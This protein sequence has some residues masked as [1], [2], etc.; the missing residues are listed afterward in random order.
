MPPGLLGML[1][2]VTPCEEARANAGT[3]GP[4]S[5]IGETTVSVGVGGQPYTVTGGKV[6]IAGPYR[7]APY[8]LSIVNPAKAGPF[9]LQEGGPVRATTIAV[10]PRTAALTVTAEPPGL[11]PRSRRSRG[12]PAADQARLRERQP[13]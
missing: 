3:C 13:A 9:D 4:E 6:Y 7:G 12:Y 10:D 1:S 5:L 8:G 2:S 11:R